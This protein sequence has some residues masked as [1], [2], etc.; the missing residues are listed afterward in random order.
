MPLKEPTP[1]ADPIPKPDRLIL[2][3][4]D[5]ADDEELLKEVFSGIDHS[6]A[7][8]FINNGERLVRSLESLPDHEL[9]CLMVLDYNMPGLNGADILRE[10]KGHKRYD[11]IPKIIWSTSGS[12][13]Y[14]KTCLALGACEY[15]IKPS[16]VR[17]LSEVARY[18]LSFCSVP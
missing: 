2:L 9:P 11:P 8:K 1:T 3:G 18:M 13:T 7:I 4:E 16:S 15:I 6:L 5:D 12:D 17:E 14:K 10:L